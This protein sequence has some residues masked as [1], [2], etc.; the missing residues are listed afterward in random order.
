MLSDFKSNVIS[1][2]GGVAECQCGRRDAAL[3]SRAA[4]PGLLTRVVEKE[5][6][7]PRHILGGQEG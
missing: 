3:Q 6:L 1:Q 5:I 7:E 2:R 4:Q